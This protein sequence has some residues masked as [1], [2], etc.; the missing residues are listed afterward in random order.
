MQNKKIVK[1][2]NL[3]NKIKNSIKSFFEINNNPVK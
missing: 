1:I 3:R 2:N